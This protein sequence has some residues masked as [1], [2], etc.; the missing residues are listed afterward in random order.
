MGQNK[1]IPPHKPE[2]IELVCPNNGLSY[3]E[4]EYEN[5]FF[6]KCHLCDWE[7]PNP[8]YK[9]KISDNEMLNVIAERWKNNRANIEPW[10]DTP[11]VTL[12]HKYYQEDIFSKLEEFEH[13]NLIEYGVSLRTAWLTTQGEALVTKIG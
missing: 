4:T 10:I 7:Q 9:S 2:T 6:V 3:F 11:D 12:A 1:Y 13:R 5:S 8:A